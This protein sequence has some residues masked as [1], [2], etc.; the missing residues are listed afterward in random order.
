MDRPYLLPAVASRLRR[1]DAGFTG[2]MP[3]S[4]VI[5][6]FRCRFNRSEPLLEK[7]LM[8]K[9]IWAF[10]AGLVL[11]VSPFTG[12]QADIVFHVSA[13]DLALSDGAAVTNWACAG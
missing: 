12:V 7:D 8:M 2:A 10:G 13:T 4:A 11:L 6:S 5:V 9:N 1:V 3:S